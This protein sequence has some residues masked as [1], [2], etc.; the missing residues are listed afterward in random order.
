MKSRTFVALAL[1]SALG[2]CGEDN[3]TTQ[4]EPMPKTFTVQI[5]NVAPWTVLKSGAQTMKTTGMSGPASSGE[6]Y[7]IV[8]TA[9]K[10]QSVSFVSMLGESN[11]WFFAPGPAG[12]PLYDAA[13]MPVTGDVSALIGL[14]N[15]GT[16][17]DQEPAVGLDTGPQQM[18]PTQGAP[19]LDPT[20]RAIG[21]A[22]VLAD[23]TTFAPPAVPAMLKA[24]LAN[25]GNQFTLHIEN[26]SVPTTLH[27]T[28]GD[29]AIHLSPP[30]WTLHIAPNPLFT[31]GMA[32]RGQGLEQIAESGNVSM[33]GLSMAELTGVA[34]PISPV[35]AL[36]HAAGE[37][38]Y[39]V[40]QADR[41]QGL[42]QIAE[43]GNSAVLTAAIPGSMVTNMPVGAAAPG[44]ALPGQS[45]QFT[46]TGKPGDA[47]SFVTMFGMSNDWF[48]GTPPG[49]VP[50][51]GLDG[52]PISGDVT[53]MISLYDAGTELDEEPGIG[54]D[55][56]PQ[57]AMPGQGAPDPIAQVREVSASEYGRSAS[58]HVRVTITPMATAM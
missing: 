33:M 53:R 2:A 43:E 50:L 31:P 19:D 45:Y 24:T 32:D 30:F 18:A 13:G 37:P 57:Q 10:G 3:D 34:T 7:D 23:G 38:L 29:R 54:P 21:A 56:G 9:G 52:M 8:F 20:V 36:V 47:L 1:C 41:G 4:T 46:V 11:D 15:A 58:A 27:T 22:I 26:V 42:E 16:E 12:I 39:S 6:A 35:L 40:G 14:W 25:K 51:F 49:G 28:Q 5:Q 17:I 48:F 55:V 44:P